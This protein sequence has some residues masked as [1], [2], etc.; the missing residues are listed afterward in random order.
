VL[1]YAL[2]PWA[3]AARW[4]PRAVA[5]NSTFIAFYPDA[6]D[7]IVG[8]ALGNVM[9]VCLSP[10]CCCGAGVRGLAASMALS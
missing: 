2:L 10:A 7:A 5:G 6:F 3:W 1:V 9:I 8:S 4:A